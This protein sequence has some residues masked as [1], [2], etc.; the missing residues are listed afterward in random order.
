VTATFGIA[1]SAKPLGYGPIVQSI[2]FTTTPISI[3]QDRDD[4]L[5]YPRFPSQSQREQRRG[6]TFRLQHTFRWQRQPEAAARSW[7][8]QARYPTSFSSADLQ[9]QKHCMQDSKTRNE[10]WKEKKQFHIAFYNH[11]YLKVFI[12]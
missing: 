2:I 7:G 5:G 9:Q 11:N 6:W 1:K 8:R 10:K 12:I 4:K 3:R